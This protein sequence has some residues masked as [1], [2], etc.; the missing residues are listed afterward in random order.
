MTG[1]GNGLD[2]WIEREE[3]R[4]TPKSWLETGNWFLAEGI[5]EGETSQDQGS[6]ECVKSKMP[7]GVW[8][9]VD[10]WLHFAV[11]TTIFAMNMEH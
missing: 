4:M 11:V 6:S 9:L 7:G 8:H 2:V 5:E 1:P 3:S 10:G